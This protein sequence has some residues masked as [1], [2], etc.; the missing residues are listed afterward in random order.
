M[1]A[2]YFQHSSFVRS[3]MGQAC[4]THRVNMF[5][6]KRKNPN[7]GTAKLVRIPPLGVVS[8]H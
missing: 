3:E 7:V 8:D 2:L 5:S 1:L 4:A 6:L